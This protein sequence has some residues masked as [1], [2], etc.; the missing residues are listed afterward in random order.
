MEI[1]KPLLLF[2][3]GII[4]VNFILMT[5]LWFFYKNRLYL[6]SMGLWVGT[7][8]NFGLQ[9]MLDKSALE[10]TL[11]FSTYFVCSMLLALIM[12][13]TAEI[14]L[15]YTRF[16][17]LFAIGVSASIALDATGASFTLVSAPTAIAV[18]F[19]MLYAALKCFISVKEKYM[20]KV[21]S[22]LL[23]VNG[24]HFLDFPFLRPLPDMAVLGFSAAFSFMILLSIFLPIFTT[25]SI[26][27]KYARMLEGE[28]RERVKVEES[29]R[30][31]KERAEAATIAKSQFLSNISHEL[32]TP[33]NGISGIA[34][35]MQ[36]NPHMTEND[37]ENLSTIAD[38]TDRLVST[39]DQILAY[40]DLDAGK[41]TLDN[42]LFNLRDLIA[43][44][45]F[46]FE[47]KAQEKGIQLNYSI[48]S[49]IPSDVYGDIERLKQILMNL[50]SNAVI[51]T[52]RGKVELDVSM[53]TQVGGQ[54]IL[55][56][57]ITDTG[58]GIAA[59]KQQQ[60]FESF[61]QADNTST[62]EYDGTGLGL[63]IVMQLVAL[64]GGNVSLKS[65]PGYGSTFTFTMKTETRDQASRA[66]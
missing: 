30:M 50:V 21:Y 40:A 12:E 31:A 53:T 3:A 17:M 6:L 35:V 46:V 60:I 7:F 54:K 22:A 8:V 61:S 4:V 41:V 23:L 19:P 25:K 13:K 5:N 55:K 47:S 16:L 64:M 18:A 38:S 45:F 63:A 1:L 29:L 58:I 2:Y 24:I 62:R 59:D 14:R 57:A 26:S 49:A 66:A 27:D 44:V 20:T 36:L 39:M 28:I 56:F 65:K 51:Y 37:K 10:I 11:A 42:E 52:P 32:R 34:Y 48:E 43:E 9:G 15:P 33:L